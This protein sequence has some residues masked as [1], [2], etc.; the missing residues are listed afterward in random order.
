VT[1][2]HHCSIE[3]FNDYCRTTHALV[4]SVLQ[5]AHENRIVASLALAA[6]PPAARAGLWGRLAEIAL[7]GR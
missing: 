6:T 1:G 4:M 7:R 5:Q 2:R 3:N